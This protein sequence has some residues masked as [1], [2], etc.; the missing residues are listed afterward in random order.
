MTL[1][2]VRSA[3]N[4]IP[5]LSGSL[6]G[7]G[8]HLFNPG[9]RVHRETDQGYVTST[10]FSPT[11]N[12]HLALGFLK[13]GRARHGQTIRIVDHMRKTDVQAEV[14]DPVFLDPQGVKLRA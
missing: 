3:R 10:C 14:C 9:D 12:A 6:A 1:I 8:A 4:A 2:G 11:L 7:S 13:N 5:L